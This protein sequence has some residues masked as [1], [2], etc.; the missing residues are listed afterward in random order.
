MDTTRLFARFGWYS[1]P[2]GQI[3]HNSSVIH[4]K[5]V[6]GGVIHFH[7]TAPTQGYPQPR[8]CSKSLMPHG[9]ERL[10]TVQGVPYYYY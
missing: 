7:V 5:T 4:R 2:W 3:W 9:K 8:P 6:R 1:K 10:S